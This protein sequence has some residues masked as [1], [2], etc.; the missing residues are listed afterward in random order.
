LLALLGGASI[1]VVSR[2]RV[3]TYLHQAKKGELRLATK[4]LLVALKGY[5]LQRQD[6]KFSYHNKEP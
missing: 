5:K 6:K 2:L 1:V 3:K 4:T